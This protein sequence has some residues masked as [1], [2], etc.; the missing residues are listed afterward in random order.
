MFDDG[1]DDLIRVS[2]A[3]RWEEEESQKQQHLLSSKSKQHEFKW[4]KFEEKK[5]SAKNKTRPKSPVKD[6]YCNMFADWRS[7][8]KRVLDDVWLVSFG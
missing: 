1:G 5:W 8:K 3:M 2:R 4:R 6:S 7:E